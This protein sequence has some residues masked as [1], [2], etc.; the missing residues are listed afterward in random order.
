MKERINQYFASEDRDEAL[1]LYERYLLARDKDIPVFGKNFYPPNIWKW[2]QEN[3][4][5]KSLKI[6]ADGFFEDAERRMILFNNLYDN[7]FPMKLIKIE[8]N[9]KFSNLI[10]KDFLGGILSLGIERN[11]IGD[12]LVD[13]NICYVPV[14]EEIESFIIYNLDKIG[15]VACKVEVVE[16][17]ILLPKA[18]FKEEVILVSSLRIDGI[19]SKIANVSRAKSQKMIEQG[20]V[21]IDYC[22]VKDKSYEIKYQERITIR[23]IGKFILENRVGNSK[24]G[25]IKIA[26]KKYT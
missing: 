6:E 15:K 9:S 3:L 7:P 22:K 5:S 4:S 12:L 18:T 10:H 16:N 2:F 23:G 21:L 8:N 1:N 19:V 25:K 11:K 20:L 13:N 26:I 17:N 24:S 14:H